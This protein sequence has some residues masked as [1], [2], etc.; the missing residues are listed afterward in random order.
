MTPDTTQASI[1][2][3]EVPEVEK[4]LKAY[5]AEHSALHRYLLGLFHDQQHRAPTVAEYQDLVG[6]HD[7]VCEA[8]E[9]Q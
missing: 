8:M 9:R 7:A 2:L 4:L 3:A 1:S 5:A 6:T